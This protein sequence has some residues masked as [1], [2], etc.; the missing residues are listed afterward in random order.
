MGQMIDLPGGAVSAYLCE[1]TGPARGGVVLIHEIWGL[2]D[3]I[4]DVADRLAAEGYITIAPDLL[5]PVGIPAELGTELQSIMFNPDPAVR[6][7][8][9]PLLR[10]RMAPIHA[11]DFARFALDALHACVDHLAARPEVA[12]RIAVTGFC[13]G[14][15]YSFALAAAD[16][17][18]VAAAPFYGSPPALDAVGDITASV[19]AF[20]GGTDER[21]MRSLPEVTAAMTD[22]GVDLTAQVYPGAGHAFFNDTNPQT[23]DPAAAADAWARLLAFLEWSLADA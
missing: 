15:S 11:P 8:G 21:L 4:T 7:A 22:A 16:P 17:R 6:S 23:Y 3:H 1:P 12:E 10:E 9:Q 2:V 20:Y 18:I 19:Y 13:F 14:G 5:G